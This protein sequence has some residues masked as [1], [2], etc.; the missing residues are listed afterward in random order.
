M[1]RKNEKQSDYLTRIGC[2]ANGISYGTRYGGRLDIFEALAGDCFVALINPTGGA[3]F[4]VFIPDFPSYMLFVKDY[5]TA[6]AA[7]GAESTQRD[8]MEALGKLFRA[9][10]GHD[11]DEVCLRCDP[12]GWGHWKGSQKNL[13]KS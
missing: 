12:A 8:I 10:H 11:T 4:E 3:S 9:E 1:S 6:Y 5:V 13:V 2:S 7:G